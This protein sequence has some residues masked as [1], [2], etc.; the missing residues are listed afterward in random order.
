MAKKPYPAD[1]ITE[2]E[3]MAFLISKQQFD[4]ALI[5]SEVFRQ[6]IFNHLSQRFTG[7]I[8]RIEAVKFCVLSVRFSSELLSH[9]SGK[10]CIKLTHQNSQ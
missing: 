5:T 9:A 8:S 3:V 6:H 2:T 10:Q 4:E 1:A 7:I